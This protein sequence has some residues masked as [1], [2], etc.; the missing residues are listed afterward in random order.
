MMPQF[1]N[2]E[3]LRINWDN[4]HAG[5]CLFALGLAK[6][7]LI[8]DQMSPLVHHAFD[9][10]PFLTFSEAAISTLAYTIQLYF[11]FSGY[12]DMAIGAALLFNI[13]LPINFNSPYKSYNI[14]DFWRRWHITLSVWLRDYLYI[15]LGGNRNGK[16]RTLLNLFLTFLLGG[17]WHGAAW[18]F[19]LWG[20]MHGIYLIIHRIW[21]RTFKLTLH[22]SLA[23][24][25][26]FLFVALAWIPFRANDWSRVDIFISG[27]IGQHGYSLT[28]SFKENIPFIFTNHF[29]YIILGS[30]LLISLFIPNSYQLLK[31]KNEVWFQ[32]FIALIFGASLLVLSLPEAVQEFMYFQF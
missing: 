13:R 19:V 12:S 9:L 11:D 27:L 15:P 8:A 16:A 20:S 10:A 14:Q 22:K 24:P 21:S 23:W 25:L 7:V 2:K 5:L 31:L 6:K 32:S 29:W 1:S 28:D 18:T 3:N 30:S 26:T 17:L 4:I